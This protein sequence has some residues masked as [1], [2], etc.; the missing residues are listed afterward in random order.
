MEYPGFL[1]PAYQAAAYMADNE[2]CVNLFAEPV[3]S[4]R[5]A[6][7][8]ALLQTPGFSTLVTV[9]QSPIRGI[10]SQSGR[11]FFVAGFAFYEMIGGV[12]TALMGTV[13]QDANPVTFCSNGDA[14]H[15]LFITSGGDMATSS[16]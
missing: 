1:G 16:T 13:V 2:R 6:T 12:A 11:V 14:G 3:E 10:F 8:G 9:S 4:P 15:Q 5:G 7:P